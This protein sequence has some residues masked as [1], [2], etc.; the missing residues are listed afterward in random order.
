MVSSTWSSP[1]SVN[2]EER[3]SKK[4]RVAATA[5]S[6]GEAI[7]NEPSSIFSSVAAP[8]AG[9]A[10][11]SA[12]EGAAVSGGIWAPP[13]DTAAAGLAAARPLLSAASGWDGVVG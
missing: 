4:G 11:A 3:Y 10:A 9:A 5:C 1:S 7:T 2:V 13:C 6:C 8:L 12:V